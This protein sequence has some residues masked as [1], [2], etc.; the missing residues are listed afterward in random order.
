MPPK[1]KKKWK[2]NT[3]NAVKKET[4]EGLECD[5]CNTFSGLECT[6]YSEDV[7]KYLKAKEVDIYFICHGC[8]ES[9][10]EL[11]SLLEIS[12][13]QLKQR[14]ELVHH[15]TRITGNEVQIEELN[16]KLANKDEKI[17]EMNTRLV[18]LEAAKMIDTEEVETI[19]QRCFKSTDFP[20]LLAAAVAANPTAQPVTPIR[21][22]TVVNDAFLE[23]EEI[24]KRKLNL[25]LHNLPEAD[26]ATDED[27][28]ISDLID[29]LELTDIVITDHIRF[30]TTTPKLLKITVETLAMKRALLSKATTLRQL[31]ENDKHAKVYIRPDLT[32]K[33]QKESKNL[34]LELK[35][36]RDED[37]AHSYKIVKGVI[38]Q[39]QLPAEL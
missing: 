3:C 28:Q 9:L 39:I 2:C 30:G 21:L 34:N 33:Q 11:R 19:A 13:V 27:T 31:P 37:P 5:I 38:Q 8:K 29:K 35:K 26:V 36:R 10:P 1:P 14:E 6:N 7:V 32:P 24:Q 15:D 17:E 25:M 22:N 16:K 23:R 20:P 4:D 18:K 12:K